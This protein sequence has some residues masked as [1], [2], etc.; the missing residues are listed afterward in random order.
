M[1]LNASITSK[2]AP[3]EVEVYPVDILLESSAVVAIMCLLLLL[4]SLTSLLL[5]MLHNIAAQITNY[6]R[7]RN[8]T[9]VR[10]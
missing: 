4:T 2:R 10:P 1:M 3:R 7:K 6:Y 5:S 8:S 9:L